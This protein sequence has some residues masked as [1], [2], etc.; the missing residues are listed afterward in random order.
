MKA[1]I[2]T[3]IDELIE[4]T[5][6]RLPSDQLKKTFEILGQAGLYIVTSQL[7]QWNKNADQKRPYVDKDKYSIEG[8]GLYDK[9]KIFFSESKKMEILFKLDKDSVI[10]ANSITEEEKQEIREYINSNY[11][12]VR[13]VLINP[14]RLDKK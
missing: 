12:M 5:K 6:T 9:Y 2:K 8:E 13:R 3:L 4:Y 10:F 7:L 11:K 1:T 14:S